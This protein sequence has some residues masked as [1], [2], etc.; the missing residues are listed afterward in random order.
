VI[1]AVSGEQD[2]RKMGGLRSHIPLTYWMMIIGTLAIT[3]VG[4]PLSPLGF[5]GFSSKDAIIESTYAAHG[6]FAPYAFF[7]LSVAALFTSFYSWRLI[8]LTFFGAARADADVMAHVHESPRVMTIPLMVLAMGAVFAG[9]LFS[10]LFLGYGHEPAHIVEHWN[11][12]W[13]GAIFVNADNHILTEAHHVPVWVS[14]TPFLAMAIGFVTAYYFYIV[15]PD[16]PNQLAE[17]LPGV[18]RFLFNKWY[19][20]ELYDAIFVK[21]A[22][23]LG[24]LL[25]KGGDGFII[26]GFGPDGVSARVVDITAQVVRLQTGFVFH[27]AFAMLIGV[28]ALVTWMLFGGVH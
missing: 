16:T 4:I 25:W 2:M 24:R 21:P 15:A 14:F 7:M 22:K 26:D 19:F 20:D 6:F 17:Y 27:Y 1:H 5:A 28:A 18:Y 3:G 9:M 23:W 12:F 10:G 8:F 13:K 11:D